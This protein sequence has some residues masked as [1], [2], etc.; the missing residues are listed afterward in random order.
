VSDRMQQAPIK[1]APT[2][3]API[4]WPAFR[5]GFLDGLST[6]GAVFIA[7]AFIAAIAAWQLVF[8]TIGLLWVVGWLA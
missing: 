2:K 1:Q 8:P 3:Q 7:V 5:R 6:C 4:N